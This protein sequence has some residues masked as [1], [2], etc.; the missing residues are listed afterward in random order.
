MSHMLPSA[1]T[2]IIV[3][4]FWFVLEVFRNSE[5]LQLI[6]E[7]VQACL[8]STSDDHWPRFDMAKLLHQP[9]L[10]ATFNENLRLH[11]HGFFIRRVEE[12]D[13]HLNNWVIPRN[14]YFIATSMPGAMD[15][16]FWCA[17]ERSSSP[18]V[19]QFWP[20][21]FLKNDGDSGTTQF[22]LEGTEGHLIPFGGG[23]HAC[24]GR[25]FVKRQNFFTLALL[26]TLYDCDIMASS[27]DMKM[28]FTRVPRGS[29]PP[30]GKVPVRM[31][32]RSWRG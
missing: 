19:D 17:G 10:Q 24:P 18:P 8:I 21:R 28:D 3:S 1:Q 32:R 12:R 11:V 31:R 29:I 15:P 23:K 9:L 2:N 6:R 20:G 26:V 16:G 4:T 13:V 7:E 22:S 30:R 5:L 25:I 14:Q 27:E